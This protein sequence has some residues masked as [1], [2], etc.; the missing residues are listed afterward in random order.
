MRLG[1]CHER[2][3]AY[4]PLACSP[5]PLA[6]G[7]TLVQ[8]TRPSSERAGRRSFPQDVR[9]LSAR[10]S[11]IKRA[12]VG[13][14]QVT[15]SFGDARNQLLGRLGLPGGWAVRRQGPCALPSCGP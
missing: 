1:P 10:R 3:P 4:A 5:V 14:G 6:Y 2:K 12:G 11:E 8:V 15:D 13:P 9:H 7:G